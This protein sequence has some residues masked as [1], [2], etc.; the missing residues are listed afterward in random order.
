MT[1]HFSA[2]KLNKALV[3]IFGLL[4][5]AGC[6]MPQDKKITYTEANQK[7]LTLCKEE[8]KLDVKLFPLKNTLWIY[9]PIDRPFYIKATE[10]TTEEKKK[11]TE[12][13]KIGFLDGHFEDHS[14]VIEYDITKIKQYP[15]KDP[16]YATGNDEEF[17][18]QYRNLFTAILR[19]YFDMEETETSQLVT[20]NQNLEVQPPEKIKT[21]TKKE[22]SPEFFVVV[23][24][25]IKTGLRM[26]Y[27]F[28][29]EDYKHYNNGGLPYEEYS[30]RQ[31]SQTTGDMEIIGDVKGNSLR[32]HEILWP[33]FLT[34]QILNRINFKYD[35]SD[36]TPSDD[37]KQE[38]LKSIGETVTFYDFND[39]DNAVLKDLNTQTTFTAPKETI[40][41]I[42]ASAEGTSTGGKFHV[43]QFFK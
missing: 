21:Y 7:F 35:K 22:H 40:K 14:F 36:F 28:N 39:F 38:I 9:M 8:Y 32:T 24:A 11:P 43:I 18:K 30:V 20:I 2:L 19:A 13:P 25:D 34:K 5:L 37:T 41:K 33:E 23:I 4:L 1:R 3:F 26:E 10:K 16:G 12:K 29:L 17:A 31:I 6:S 15:P 27:T 42:S